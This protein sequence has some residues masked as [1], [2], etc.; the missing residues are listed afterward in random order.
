MR[1]FRVHTKKN[2]KKRGSIKSKSK[3]K[4]YRKKAGKTKKVKKSKS[5]KKKRGGNAVPENSM[6]KM[7]PSNF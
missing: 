3:S 6:T 7:S 5:T 4:L 2:L 1:L